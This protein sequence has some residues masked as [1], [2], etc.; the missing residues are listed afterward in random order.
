MRFVVFMV[1]LL[2]CGPSDEELRAAEKQRRLARWN[3]SYAPYIKV[4]CRDDL[5]SVECK[6]AQMEARKMF[7]DEEERDR[8]EAREAAVSR[9]ARRPRVCTPVGSSIICN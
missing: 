6:K 5:E 3:E 1:L 4:A 2:S 7:L 8:R 9:R